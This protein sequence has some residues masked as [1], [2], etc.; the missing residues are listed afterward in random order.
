M[1]KT[2][3]RRAYRKTVDYAS[4]LPIYQDSSCLVN[5]LIAA[6]APHNVGPASVLRVSPSPLAPT[7]PSPALGPSSRLLAAKRS[8]TRKWALTAEVERSRAPARRR[9]RPV[10]RA[11]APRVYGSSSAARTSSSS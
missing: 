8:S 3:M 5:P 9:P 6:N 7:I 2:T 10:C 1:R 4:R 11:P